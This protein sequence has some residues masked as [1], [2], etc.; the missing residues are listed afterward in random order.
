MYEKIEKFIKML[1]YRAFNSPVDKSI[2]KMVSSCG[3]WIT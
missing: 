1:N 2:L 3:A